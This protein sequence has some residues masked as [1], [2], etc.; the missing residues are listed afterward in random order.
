MNRWYFIVALTAT[1]FSVASRADE[2]GFEQ[3][4]PQPFVFSPTVGATG[5]AQADGTVYVIGGTTLYALALADGTLTGSVTLDPARFAAITGVAAHE[6]RVAI[7]ATPAQDRAT[8]PGSLLLYD[9]AG[10][11]L[12]DERPVGIGPDM[13]TFTNDGS[14]LLVANEGE[15]ECRVDGDTATLV[16]PPGSVTVVDLAGSAVAAVNTATFDRFNGQKQSLI[17]AGVRIYGP[18][19]T[20]AQDL[21]PEHIAVSTHDGR[22]WI[23]LQ[24]NNAI[25]ELDLSRDPPRFSAIRSARGW[26]LVPLGLKDHGVPSNALDV[27]DQ[28]GVTIDSY[29]GLVGMYLPDGIDA[30]KIRGETYLFTA[31]EGDARDYPP[32]FSEERRVGELALDPAEF[33][34]TEAGVLGRLRV[35]ST[36]G[37]VGGVYHRLYAFGGRSFAVW[38]T[39]GRLVY[40]SGD[41]IE[42]TLAARFPDHLYESRSDDKGPEPEEL[43]VGRIDRDPYLFVGLERA[44]GVMAFDVADPEHPDFAGFIAYPV[45]ASLADGER[46]ERLA[47]VP[48]TSNP[49]SGK[50]LLLVTNEVTRTLQAY[51]VTVPG[52]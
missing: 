33:T 31:N 45:D 1:S 29:P 41:T 48:A 26:P 22:A 49:A 35:T 14:R 39:R 15:P 20:V 6:S 5:V 2:L 36:A 34:A 13:V 42:R 40:D 10:L 50:P 30:E 38:N 37:S 25:A 18:D 16:D 44:N 12:L 7:T 23:T 47:F 4:W 11:T 43:I 52:S 19:A 17:N 8:T 51:T 46:P 27:S 24:E 9:A 21:E 28:N 32:C 3:A